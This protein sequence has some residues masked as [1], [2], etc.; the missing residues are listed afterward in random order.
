[1]AQQ[2]PPAGPPP[3]GYGQPPGAPPP[4]GAYGPGGGGYGAA[5]PRPGGLTAAAVLVFIVGGLR[6]L[7]GLIALVAVLGATDEIAAF[8]ASSGQVVGVVAVAVLIT[9]AVAIVQ[10][11]GGVAAL[12]QRRRAF[13]LI[14]A[15]CIAG[16]VIGLFGLVSGGGAAGGTLFAVLFLLVDIAAIVL[17]VTNKRYLINP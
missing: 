4:P 15:G 14:L 7:F 6:I 9:L 10:I 11:L 17:T 1:M 12:R 13:P 8:G 2:P 5:G 16:I 3:G